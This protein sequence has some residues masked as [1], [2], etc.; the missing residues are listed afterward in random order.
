MDILLSIKYDLYR[1][2]DNETGVNLDPESFLSTLQSM[3]KPHPTGS[4]DDDDDL[5]VSSESSEDQGLSDIMVD[6][7]LELADT[8]MGKSFEVCIISMLSW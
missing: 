5:S 1:T 2:V 4:N 3:L 8:E 7:D 6:M